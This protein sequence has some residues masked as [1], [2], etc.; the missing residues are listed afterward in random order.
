MI[1]HVPKFEGS[2]HARMFTLDGNE[3]AVQEEAP[4]SLLLVD[5]W[6]RR[7]TFNATLPA[8]GAAHYHIEMHEGPRPL[9][10][11]SPCVPHSLETDSGLLTSLKTR[12]GEEILASKALLP[13]VV[14]DLA[15][16]WGMEEWSYRN[17]LG[18][19]SVVPGSVRICE[20]GPVRRITEASF[21]YGKS[22][23]NSRTFAYSAFPFLEVR[24]RIQWNEWRK[25]LK[26]SIPT[27]LKAPQ[28]VCET[29]GGAISR[30]A[31]GQEHLQGRWMIMQ[32]DAS[33]SQTA[34]AVVNSG[35][36]GFDVQDGDLRI[37]LL[38]SPLYC[39]ER[40][41]PLEHARRLTVMDQGVHDVRLLLMAGNLSELRQS[42]T[43]LAD[44]ISAP[45]YVLAHFPIGEETPPVQELLTVNPRTVRLLTCK[46]SWDGKGM[47]LRLQEIAG[48]RTVGEVRISNPA[49][50]ITME[51]TPFEIKTVRIE[52]EGSWKEVEMIEEK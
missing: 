1:D 11:T 33:D 26:L 16:S 3:I 22:T 42:V 15:D 35:Q 24:L 47:V 50:A 32:A 23:I 34:F 25:R 4:D 48:V 13:L 46:Q 2:W 30:P 49:M 21:E 14:E 52:K 40:T 18:A 7:L 51:F 8:I 12:S 10:R 9:V 44:W 37:S 31:D 36:Y 41:F 19:F 29:P 17:V 28:V 6:R 38:R 5:S 20:E 43:G 27:L 39:Y 45:P